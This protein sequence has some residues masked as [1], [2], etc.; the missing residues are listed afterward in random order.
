MSLNSLHVVQPNHISS[1]L[2]DYIKDKKNADLEGSASCFL[3]CF[4]FHVFLFLF[5]FE[6]TMNVLFILFVNNSMSEFCIIEQ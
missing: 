4:A 1:G 6:N 2:T 3:F 5:L